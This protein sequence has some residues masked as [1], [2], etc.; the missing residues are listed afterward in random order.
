MNSK[1]TR[2]AERTLRHQQN[3]SNIRLIN[4][5]T[6]KNRI[7][8]PCC[9]ALA[10]LVYSPQIRT[11][12]GA[13]ARMREIQMKQLILLSTIA[14]TILSQLTGEPIPANT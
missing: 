13:T 7:K 11:E 4:I 14:R 3:L 12:H 10:Q 8:N 5:G 9:T 6:N 2:S 1:G